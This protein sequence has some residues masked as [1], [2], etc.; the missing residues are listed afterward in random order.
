MPVTTNLILPDYQVI[1]PWAW[2]REVDV[3]AVDH[4]LSCTGPD[5]HADIAFA[6]DRAR[7]WAGG[8][9]WLLMEQATRLVY[10]GS[11]ALSRPPGRMLRDS[12][13]YLARGSD[14]VLFFQW[15]ASRAGAEM[16]HSAMLPHAGPQPHQ[17]DCGGPGSGRGPAV[18]HPGSRSGGAAARGR[19]GRPRTVRARLASPVTPVALVVA[20]G[21]LMLTYHPRNAG[22]LSALPVMFRAPG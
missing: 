22:E 12:L 10:A 2:R 21:C 19:R 4:Y 15:R 20:T 5:G 16:W 8:R 9:P 14:S 17:R 7:S 13:G 3:V 11:R 6:A 18:R 1:D